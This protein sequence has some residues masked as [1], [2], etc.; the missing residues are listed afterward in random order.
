MAGQINWHKGVLMCDLLS[1]GRQ[2]CHMN[3]ASPAGHTSGTGGPNV[4]LTTS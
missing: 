1:W 3:L 4:T 2:L